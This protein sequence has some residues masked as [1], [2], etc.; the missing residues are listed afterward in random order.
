MSVSQPAAR[1][2]FEAA[3]VGLIGYGAIGR[4]LYRSLAGEPG[5]P[6]PTVLL[7]VGSASRAALPDGAAA[8]ADAAALVAARPDI[9]VEAAGHRAVAEALPPV[10]EAGIPVIIASVG[11][12]GDPAL[13]ERLSRAAR[14]GGTSLKI[15]SGAVGGLDYLRS[16]ASDP[17]V[18][19]RYTSRKPPSSFREE[20]AALDLQA[21]TLENEVV[22]FE[23]DAAAAARLYP[24]NL[25]VA[26]AVALAVGAD[27]LSVRVVA[28]PAVERNTHEIEASGAA[29][30]ARMSFANVPSPANPKTSMLTALSLLA[31]LR[32]HFDPLVF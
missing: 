9:V 8:V 20:L 16:V 32:Q 12:L 13:L 11:A 30:T 21:S 23:G 19:V 17:S 28:D 7:P 22:L 18:R 6:R 1:I 25:N 26:L 24:R 3:H 29:G 14:H 27:R 2:R 31:A 10:L 5:R 4:E 15:P